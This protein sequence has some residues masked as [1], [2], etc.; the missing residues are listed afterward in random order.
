MHLQIT[1]C[2]C[3]CVDLRTTVNVIPYTLHLAFEAECLIVLG[4]LSHCPRA[5]HWS[6]FLI[7]HSLV[8]QS[9]R[10]SPPT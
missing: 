9:P 3:L 6:A 2:M 4:Q 8:R 7:N 5:P 10:D 1:V